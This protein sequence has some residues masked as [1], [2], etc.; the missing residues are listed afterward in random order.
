MSKLPYLV[1]E[2]NAALEVYLSGRI[3]Q[4]YNRTAFI[5]CDDCTELASK[6]FLLRDTLAW[7]DTKQNGNFKRYKD[8]TRE[9]RA[10]FLAKRP[11]DHSTVDELLRRMESR[12]ER[13]NAFFHSTQLLDLN[14]HARDCVEA[15][16]DLLDYGKLL[17]SA[18][19]EISVAAV[20]NM[21]TCE[22][23]LRVDKKTYADPSVVPRFNALLGTRP[24]LGVTPKPRGCEIVHYPE[25]IHLRLAIRNGGKAFRDAIRALL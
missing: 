15:L 18:D 3:G 22:A 7:K 2:V 19:W 23:V 16:V 24:R 17:F 9:V 25:D 20:G 11:S 13:R 8:V 10:V 6:L 5:L 4:Q 14:F 1:A 12:R 21:E